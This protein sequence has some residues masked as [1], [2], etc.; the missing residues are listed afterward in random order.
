MMTGCELNTSGQPQ[1]I[2][3][4]VVPSPV[5]LQAPYQWDTREELMVWTGNAVS[6]G[7]FSID[8]GDSNGA[9]AIPLTDAAKRNVVLRGPDIVPPARSIRAVRVRYQWLPNSPSSP[10]F[11]LW[12]AF[13]RGNPPGGGLQPRAYAR[14]KA[15]VGWKESESGVPVGHSELMPLDVGYV[16]FS[17]FDQ[18]P[19]VLMIDTITLVN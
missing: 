19:G 12:V 13:D 14:L 9:I 17:A 1:F 7:P 18:N 16:Y 6:H 3:G 4:P 10:E 15:G 11:W 8:D 2:P 5:P